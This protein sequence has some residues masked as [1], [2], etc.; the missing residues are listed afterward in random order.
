VIVFVV[1][2]VYSITSQGHVPDEIKTLLGIAGGV[3]F[4]GIADDKRRRDR[5][6]EN[7]ANRA[8]AKVD[9][10]TDVAESEHPG[11]TEGV[12]GG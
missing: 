6:V 11:S 5:D 9:R 3:W 7:T 10:L 4:G 1:Y 12:R 8:E 2:I